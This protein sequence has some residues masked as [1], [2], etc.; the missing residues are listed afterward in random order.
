MQIISLE[1]KRL[2]I[3]QFS[4]SLCTTYQVGMVTR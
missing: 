1:I 4:S 3:D 2:Q